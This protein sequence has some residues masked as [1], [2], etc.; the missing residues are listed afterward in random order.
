VSPDTLA[1]CREEGKGTGPPASPY[2]RDELL[3]MLTQVGFTD[4]EAHAG[5]S[6]APATAVD[7]TAAVVA[8]QAE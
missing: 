1:H 7:T 4:I 3:P 8:R 5:D 6:D 2:V